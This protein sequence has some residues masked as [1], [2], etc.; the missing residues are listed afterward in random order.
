MTP[1]HPP[2][3]PLIAGTVDQ[4][5]TIAG[6]AFSLIKLSREIRV[7]LCCRV[8]FKPTIDDLSSTLATSWYYMAEL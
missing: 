8:E 3:I 5:V 4:G 2:T 7:L 6:R 1:F